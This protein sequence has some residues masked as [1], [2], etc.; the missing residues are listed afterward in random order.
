MRRSRRG[1]LTFAGDGFTAEANFHLTIFRDYVSFAGNE[2]N[3]TWS[4]QSRLDLRE[5]KIDKPELVAFRTL[6]L[7]PHW[8]VDV[9][10]RKY[11]FAKVKWRSNIN[12]ELKS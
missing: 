12:E 8:F 10:P 1:D 4:D 2:D 11:E 7:R 9:D 6:E 5:A 3:Q